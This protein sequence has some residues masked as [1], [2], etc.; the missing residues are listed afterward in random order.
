MT[1][2]CL[3]LSTE[4]IEQ[5]NQSI[6]WLL[7]VLSVS[8]DDQNEAYDDS[9]KSRQIDIPIGSE[10]QPNVQSLVESR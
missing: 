7:G 1:S 5:P 8:S 4:S 6:D 9:Q 3:K 2:V 10:K